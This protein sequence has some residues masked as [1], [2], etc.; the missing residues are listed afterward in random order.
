M[1]AFADVTYYDGAATPVAHTLKAVKQYEEKGWLVS[2]YREGLASLP[3]EAQV[4]M[5]LRSRVLPSGVEEHRV[6]TAV[7]V[8]ETVSGQNAAGYT[9]APQIAYRDE[10]E[11]VQFAHPR[12]AETGR[13]LVRQLH[14]N[15]LGNVITSVA[16][17]QTGPVPEAFDK[18]IDP[19]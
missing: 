9:A 15:A 2:L 16:A 17:V 3:T 6:R 19:S 7:P 13:R 11:T 12:S 14:I 10:V 8:M 18:L 5:T 1:S 4:N